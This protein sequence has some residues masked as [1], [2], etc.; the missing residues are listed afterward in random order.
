MKRIIILSP[1]FLL[2]MISYHSV[3]A[4]EDY[5]VKKRQLDQLRSLISHAESISSALKRT[6]GWIADAKLKEVGSLLGPI[7]KKI[8]RIAQSLGKEVYF[9]VVGSDILVDMKRLKPVTANLIHP[10]RNAI[11]HGIESPAERGKKPKIGQIR[12]SFAFEDN[13]IIISIQDDG[14]GFDR[15]KLINRAAEKGLITLDEKNVNLIDLVF[16]QQLSSKQSAD[17]VGGRGIGLNALKHAVEEV[18]GK[19]ELDTEAGHGSRILIRI[20]S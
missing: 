17:M 16:N 10:I 2:I 3:S 12:L 9:S 19:I 8:E 7:H 20:P 1:L 18:H 15:D 6:D 11:L 4:V 13:E 5:T 14:R